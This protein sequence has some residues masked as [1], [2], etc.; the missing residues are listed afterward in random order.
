MKPRSYFRELERIPLFEPKGKI[1]ELKVL[2]GIAAVSGIA[3]LFSIL[4]TDFKNIYDSDAGEAKGY[5]ILTFLSSIIA[6]F[7]GFSQILRTG[8]MKDAQVSLA[9]SYLLRTE[10]I[11]ER[12][13]AL[14]SNFR[15][16]KELFVCWC[17][18]RQDAINAQ[19]VITTAYS[20]GPEVCLS[21]PRIY[22]PS[23][24]RV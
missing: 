3:H 16:E 5:F 7:Y 2:V 18:D 11:S 4:T 20:E 24:N 22:D 15:D 14:I 1:G 17:V 12:P 8:S 6:F 21:D 9:K 23:G 10:N 19:K 13:Y